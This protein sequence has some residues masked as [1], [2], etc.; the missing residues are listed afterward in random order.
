M[1]NHSL[2]PVKLRGHLAA[3]FG[4]NRYLDVASPTEAVRALCATVPGFEDYLRKS[5]GGYKVLVRNVPV[6]AEHLHDPCGHQEIR[7]V[8]I[9]EGAGGSDGFAQILEG[10]ALIG[11]AYVLAPYTAGTSLAWVPGALGGLGASLALGGIARLMAGSPQSSPDSKSSFLFNNMSNT[12]AQG[13]PV[14]ILYGQ[15]TIVP[16]LIGNGIDTEAF[17]STIFGVGFDGVGTW[18]G[19]GDA[20]PWG[21]SLQ[22]L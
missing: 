9:I 14:P 10:A 16:P 8:P 18:I 20:T 1:S 13:I 4:A 6:T 11:L 19:D 7:I 15:M 21:A 22:C 17:S 5:K 3:R 2:T 12:Q